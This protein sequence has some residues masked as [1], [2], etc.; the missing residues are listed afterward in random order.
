MLLKMILFN[1]IIW[2]QLTSHERQ[3]PIK[4]E[5][6]QKWNQTIISA[7]KPSVS[8]TLRLTF[9]FL[10]CWS[11]CQLMEFMLLLCYNDFSQMRVIKNMFIWRV[12]VVHIHQCLYVMIRLNEPI[13][14]SGIFYSSADVQHQTLI[15]WTQSDFPLF[16]RSSSLSDVL[17][18]FADPSTAEKR[19]RT[20]LVRWVED[21][22]AAPQA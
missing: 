21:S 19:H 9:Q 16:G 8:T 1:N 22:S 7:I 12:A 18:C 2:E 11:L 17:C 20:E 3:L 13:K 15:T 10:T 4:L 6:Q 5:W 14:R